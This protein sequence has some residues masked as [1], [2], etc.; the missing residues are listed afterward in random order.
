MK[1]SSGED[2]TGNVFCEHDQALQNNNR[3]DAVASHLRND[4]IRYGWYYGGANP[5][6]AQIHDLS[7]PRQ[8]LFG[9]AMPNHGGTVYC[10]V[11]PPIHQS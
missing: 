3:A 10:P 5:P 1:R 2:M 4:Q 7:S 11:R 8:E 6:N 9:T